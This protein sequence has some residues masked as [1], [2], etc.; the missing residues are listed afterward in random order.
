MNAKRFDNIM[1]KTKTAPVRA[2]PEG[3]GVT[4][5]PAEGRGTAPAPQV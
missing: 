1:L 4:F 5:A 3:I 2:L